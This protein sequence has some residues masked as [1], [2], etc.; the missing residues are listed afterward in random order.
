MGFTA[1]HRR[2][3]AA[4][5]ATGLAALGA[6]AGATHAHAAQVGA[7]E[8]DTSWTIPNSVTPTEIS[9]EVLINAGECALV[10]TS[11]LPF[12]ALSTEF[13]SGSQT[14]TYEGTCAEGFIAFSDG[15][16][17]IFVG[18]VIVWERQ[19]DGSAFVVTGAVVPAAAPCTGS[20]TSTM[21]WSG[22]VAEAA[23]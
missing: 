17:A 1:G 19:A 3:L 2:V 6:A 8:A 13:V 12:E 10:D 11:K 4:A 14:Y 16:V 15:D 9:G 22:V 5:L 7:C 20:P 18:G 21:T 23:A